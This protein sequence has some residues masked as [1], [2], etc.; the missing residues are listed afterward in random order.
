MNPR[1]DKLDS[2][3]PASGL[4]D[5][6]PS[7]IDGWDST[8]D[9]LVSGWGKLSDFFSGENARR[10]FAEGRRGAGLGVDRKP[11]KND[12]AILAKILQQR[13]GGKKGM[14]GSAGAKNATATFRGK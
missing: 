11:L 2:A 1:S 7:K 13:G 12:T 8:I 9:S 14:G 5:A 10:G 3:T 6:P 4:T